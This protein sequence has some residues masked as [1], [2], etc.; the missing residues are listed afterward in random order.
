[1]TK[2]NEKNGGDTVA[3]RAMS[4]L[5]LIEDVELAKGGRCTSEARD[6]E[7]TREHG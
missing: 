1:M 2:T 5:E 4:L 7:R 3:K 6:G